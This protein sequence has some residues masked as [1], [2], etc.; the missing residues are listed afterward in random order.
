MP[1]APSLKVKK[2]KVKVVPKVSRK[3][4][5][6]AKRARKAE[7]ADRRYKNHVLCDRNSDATILH[8]I[9]ASEMPNPYPPNIAKSARRMIVVG[10]NGAV[11]VGETQLPF[12]GIQ[13]SGH[14][15]PVQFGNELIAR[16]LDQ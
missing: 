15:N 7:K 12:R 4:K 6:A 13:I 2:T 10:N 1:K 5:K 16:V 9:S 11:V 14:M 8:S 3:E